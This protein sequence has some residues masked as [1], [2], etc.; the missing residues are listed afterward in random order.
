LKPGSE[1]P[2]SGRKIL[3]LIEVSVPV[4]SFTLISLSLEDFETYCRGFNFEVR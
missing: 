2:T 1:T 3:V 4:F